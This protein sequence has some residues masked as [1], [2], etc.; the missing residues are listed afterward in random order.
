MAL[1]GESDG[2]FGPE[3]GKTRPEYARAEVASQS[4]KPTEEIH[5][6]DSKLESLQIHDRWK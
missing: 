5:D 6:Q 4:Y 2:E 1:G 3:G